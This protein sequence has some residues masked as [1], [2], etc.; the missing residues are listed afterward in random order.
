[1]WWLCSVPGGTQRA[2]GE[3][4]WVVTYLGGVMWVGG[5]IIDG[6]WWWWE[7]KPVM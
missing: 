6:G 1:M 2:T 5:V 3:C 7:G 4:G